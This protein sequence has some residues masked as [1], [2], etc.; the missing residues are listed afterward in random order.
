M[1]KNRTQHKD[2]EHHEEPQTNKQVAMRIHGLGC[3]SNESP[4]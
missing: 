3:Y 2:Q 4:K 1:H